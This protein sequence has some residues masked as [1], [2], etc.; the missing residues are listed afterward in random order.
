MS[1]VV[2]GG[3]LMG[4]SAAFHLR[5]ADPAPAVTVLERVRTGA[6]ASGASAAGVRAM[7]RDP[8]ER[9]LA[10]ESLRRWPELDRELEAKTG[11]R[12]GGGL[13]VALDD[14]AWDAAAGWAAEQC[15][16]GV[17][18]E[19]VNAESTRRLAPDVAP[20]C[21]GGVYSPIDGQ[22]DAM[23]TVKAFATAARRLGARI[24]E[25]VGV[26]ALLA[27]GG[28]V[29]GVERSDGTRQS[30]D[31]LIV[32]AGAWT[33][34]LLARLGVKLPLD[35]RPLQMLLTEPASGALA[36]VLGC[37]DRKISFK[38]LTDGAYLIGGGWPG[39]VVDHEANRWAVLDESVRSSLEVAREVYPPVADCPLARS[40]IG[41]EAFLPDELPVIGPVPGADGLLVAAGFSGHGFALSPMI[42][43]VLARLALGRDAL[44]SLWRDLRFDRPTLAGS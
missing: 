15:H 19:I 23:A 3:G 44:R 9:R 27:E 26:T 6:A 2:V 21:L 1:V 43:D 31:V 34:P 10:L 14:K 30:C 35:T 11:Y 13:R 16:H 40:W 22:A 4:L 36:P 39:Q 28:R 37:F 12:R 32:T 20:A 24:E 17:P 42:G 18:L 25:G 29:V 41:L 8:A 33:A 5:R 7:G 38:Q